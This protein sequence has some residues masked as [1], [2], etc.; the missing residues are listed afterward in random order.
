MLSPEEV[1]GTKLDIGWM[2]GII[3]TLGLTMVN[4]VPGE[5]LGSSGFSYG[6]GGEGRARLCFVVSLMMTFGGLTA[7]IVCNEIQGCT[8][9]VSKNWR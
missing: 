1:K 4:M 9:V 7:A 2:A 8:G 6:E 3:S 5:L